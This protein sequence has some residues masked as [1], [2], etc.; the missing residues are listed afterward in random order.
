MTKSVNPELLH[1]PATRIISGVVDVVGGCSFFVGGAVRDHFLGRPAKDV[2]LMVSGVPVDKLVSMLEKVSKVDVV[3][4]SFGVIKATIGGETI[5]VALP[6]TEESVGSGHCDFRIVADPYLPVELD[7]ARRDLTMN[8]VFV[9]STTGVVVD[10]F[11]GVGDIHRGVIKAVGVP[12]DRFSE[13]P[14][15]QIRAVRFVS[16]LGFVMDKA[17]TVAIT[18]HVHLIPTISAERVGEEMSRLLMGNHAVVAI[19]DMVKLGIMQYVIP[20]WT[21]SVGFEQHNSHHQYTVDEHVLRALQH[22]VDRGAGLRC[23]WA[24]LLHDISKP[25]TYSCGED[26]C[27]HFYEHEKVGAEMVPTILGRLKLPTEFVSDISM[28]VREHLCP[29]Y[30]WGKTA[31]RRFVARIGGCLDDSLLLRECDLVAHSADISAG[32]RVLIDGFREQI[33]NMKEIQ[34]FTQANLAL[35]GHRIAA[36]FGVTGAGIGLMKKFATSAVV[37]G[38]IPNEIEAIMM[39][40]RHEYI[41]QK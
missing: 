2:D 12:G 5:D 20:E 3:G 17:T 41:K 23:R 36:E 19:R 13:D 22:A 27:G 14:L 9:N 21:P 8:A 32:A 6:R 25:N 33:L 39:Y 26:G 18:E 7:A 29:S 11:G 15:R 28:M 37:D 4:R 24:V 35:D 10:A 30:D 40:L 16:T 38:L 31:L 1:T 34:G